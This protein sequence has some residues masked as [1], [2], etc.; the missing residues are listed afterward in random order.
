MPARPA[1]LHSSPLSRRENQILDILHSR[2]TASAADIHRLLPDA[3]GYST[4]RKLLEILEDKKIVKHTVEG[5]RFVYSPVTPRSVA[6]R[7]A[8][9]HL[10]NTF[11]SGSVE[12]A[13]VALFAMEE[14]KVDRKMLGRIERES[15]R[16]REE[17][18]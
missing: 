13:A 14:G 10:L 9:R 8:L 11:F 6:T 12:D 2:G 4:V 17:G 16:A 1:S 5:R 18:R 7:S 3:P 15:R